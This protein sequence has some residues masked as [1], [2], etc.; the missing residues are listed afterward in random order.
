MRYNTNLHEPA[1]AYSAFSLM[2]SELRENHDELSRRYASLSITVALEGPSNLDDMRLSELKI[3]MDRAEAK[4][5]Q[6]VLACAYY[7]TKLLS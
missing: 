6:C 2:L 3:Q 4:M 5:H 1:A 7:G